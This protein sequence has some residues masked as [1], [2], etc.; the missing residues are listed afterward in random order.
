MGR[1]TLHEEFDTN[2]VRFAEAKSLTDRKLYAQ[3]IDNILDEWNRGDTIA[4]EPI[5]VDSTEGMGSE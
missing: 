3:I 1:I 2:A 5:T 4:F